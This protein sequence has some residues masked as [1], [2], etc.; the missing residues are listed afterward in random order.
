[1]SE[2]ARGELK[3][4]GIG[5]FLVD[6][7]LEYAPLSV[8]IIDDRGIIK[9]FNEK[10][11]NLIRWP[12]EVWQGKG[13]IFSVPPFN[14]QKITDEFEKHKNS[15]NGFEF[16]ISI[17]GQEAMCGVYPLKRILNLPD[18]YACFVEKLKREDSF[19]KRGRRVEGIVQL[20]LESI[21]DAVLVADAE[22]KVIS[23]GNNKAQSL[24]GYKKDELIGMP[25]AK[26]HPEEEFERI[27]FIFERQAKGELDLA[28]DIPFLKKDG[29]VI[30]IDV[31]STKIDALDRRYVVGV[32]RDITYKK[33]LLSKLLKTN[34]LLE[35]IFEKTH[36][37]FAF[38]SE[39]F[40]IIRVNEKFANT[41]G[42]DV[43]QF[44]GRNFFDI[45]NEPELKTLFEEVALLK[46]SLTMKEFPITRPDG[47]VVYLDFMLSSLSEEPDEVK[48][49][50]F[51]G[52]DVTELVKTKETLQEVEY[53]KN[54]V[55]HELNELV[56]YMT[57]DFEI[58][59][60]NKPFLEYSLYR[61]FSELTGKKCYLAL[62]AEHKQCDTCPALKTL[63]DLKPHSSYVRFKN[64]KEFYVRTFPDLKNGK[65]RGIVTAC[66]DITELKKREKRIERLNE[67]LRL[68]K[69]INHII[70]RE[71]TAEGIIEKVTDVL[72][73]KKDYAFSALLLTDHM[74]IP[75]LSGIKPEKFADKLNK[76]LSKMNSGEIPECLEEAFVKDDPVISKPVSCKG[77]EF[78]KLCDKNKGI[79]ARKLEYK[80]NVM[81]LLMVCAESESLNDSEELELFKELSR[82]ISYALYHVKS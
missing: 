69:D 13:A 41:L 11:K 50:I 9:G 72:S 54:T 60:A 58:K 19:G 21:G 73:N 29:S 40:R 30:Y 64:G 78:F 44:V 15:L 24:L 18:T 7:M 71:E 53:I 12:L 36:L 17:D 59:W 57:P 62:D 70:M 35:A 8:F 10:T 68:I 47:K 2:N 55:L 42:P 51:S 56:S 80:G 67:M 4:K 61:D 38:M 25:I 76:L 74:G 26:L 22:T 5:N 34:R 6:M 28:E 1:M 79:I 33:A 63:K 48:G 37:M 39:D 75:V 66:L 16:K 81:G 52:T 23:Y 49:I 65:L 77:C 27:M 14:D 20:L 82:D 43:E 31:N 3:S 46:K 45:F 32:L